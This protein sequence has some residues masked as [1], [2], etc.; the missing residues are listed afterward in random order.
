MNAHRWTALGMVL[1]A[2]AALSLAAR[3]AAPPAP[4]G[5][6]AGTPAP[7][8]GPAPVPAEVPAW[9]AVDA[10]W[11]GGAPPVDAARPDR[12]RPRALLKRYEGLWRNPDAAKLGAAEED[13]LKALEELPPDELVALVRQ[14]LST[15]PVNLVLI[16]LENAMGGTRRSEYEDALVMAM[17]E[18]SEQPDKLEVLSDVTLRFNPS[19]ENAEVAARL[20]MKRR[21]AGRL[22]EHLGG[23]AARLEGDPRRRVKQFAV[24][25][26][27]LEALGQLVDDRADVARLQGY[28]GDPTTVDRARRALETA[29]ASALSGELRRQIQR[30]LGR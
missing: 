14:G 30:A 15:R 1:G 21:P 25:Q 2:A 27:L 12:G 17:E 6:A 18:V 4:A 5:P 3:P 26:H 7:R 9:P 22:A 28:L 16:T 24:E 20:L 29:S 11:D 19:R 13:L 8:R 23:F 10:G